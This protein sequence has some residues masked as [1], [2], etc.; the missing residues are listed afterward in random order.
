MILYIF[1]YLFKISFLDNL[2]TSTISF[3]LPKASVP[4]LKSLL[5]A[6]FSHYAESALLEK[7]FSGVPLDNLLSNFSP[8]LLGSTSFCKGFPQKDKLQKVLK[9]T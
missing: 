2:F 1:D 8:L 9:L 3:L 4:F 6:L 5:P 7:G